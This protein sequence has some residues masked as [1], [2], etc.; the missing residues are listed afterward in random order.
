MAGKVLSDWTTVSVTECAGGAGCRMLLVRAC[1][2]I[3]CAATLPPSSR[4]I[5]LHVPT[6]SQHSLPLQQ[7]P[8]QLAGNRFTSHS[9]WRRSWWSLGRGGGH[10]ALFCNRDVCASDLQVHS[11]IMKY[12]CSTPHS[13]IFS[14]VDAQTKVNRRFKTQFV[15]RSKHSVCVIKT[16]F[17]TE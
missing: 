7:I 5:D 8:L 10:R 6:A 3:C 1:W 15:P 16:L 9:L 17:N 2:S 4:R 14:F 12:L 11:T 13:F